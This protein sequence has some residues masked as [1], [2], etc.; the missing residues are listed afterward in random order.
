M[1]Y[2]AR[3]LPGFQDMAL[4][5]A[6]LLELEGGKQEKGAVSERLRQELSDAIC[7]RAFFVE[8]EPMRDAK[9]SR[10]GSQRPRRD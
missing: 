9:P 6:L 5:Y 4:R 1:K 10:R 3:S 8:D 2:L 7:D